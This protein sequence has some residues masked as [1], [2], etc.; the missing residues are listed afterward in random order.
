MASYTR[1]SKSVGDLGAEAEERMA[2]NYQR[3]IDWVMYQL[4]L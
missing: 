4:K 2:F 1:S 3:R